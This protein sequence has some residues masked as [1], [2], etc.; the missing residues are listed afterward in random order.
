MDDEVTEGQSGRP[1]VV[2]AAGALESDAV[3]WTGM[4]ADLRAAAAT[5]AGQVLSTS[6]FSFAGRE[7]AAAYDALRARVATLL[8]EGAENLDAV[9]AA[10]RAG[11]AAYTAEEAAAAARLREAG[12]GAPR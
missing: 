8:A 10:L 1:D 11:A 9:A 4:A 12:G 7:V 5:A 2:V 6:A 3:R